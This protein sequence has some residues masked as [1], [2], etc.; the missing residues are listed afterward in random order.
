MKVNLSNF[1][2][3]D[4]DLPHY[5]TAPYNFPETEEERCSTSSSLDLERDASVWCIVERVLRGVI[6]P[7][8]PTTQQSRPIPRFIPQGPQRSETRGPPRVISMPVSHRLSL[9]DRSSF[10]ITVSHHKSDERAKALKRF[11]L[12][13]NI[14]GD[15]NKAFR[16]KDEFEINDLVHTQAESSFPV[17]TQTFYLRKRGIPTYDKAKGS[18]TIT[19]RDGKFFVS[20]EMFQVEARYYQINKRKV[21][22][23]PVKLEEGDNIFYFEEKRKLTRLFNVN[24]RN[25]YFW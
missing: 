11:F 13:V 17:Y 20:R 6:N 23:E 8:P 21:T 2:I 7:T 14:Y 12:E 22:K 4:F 10:I 9:E 19:Y 24:I 15:R 18:I 25:K 16:G 3:T 5:D 1:F